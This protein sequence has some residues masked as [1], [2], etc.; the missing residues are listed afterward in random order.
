ML[1][2]G[3]TGKVAI[4]TGGSEGL[5]RAAALRAL[6]PQVVLSMYRNASVPIGLSRT[7]FDDYRLVV[8]EANTLNNIGIVYADTGQLKKALEFYEQALPLLKTV[9]D[10]RGEGASGRRSRAL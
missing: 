8:R 5:G 3:L 4:V 10:K 2:L 7:L 1:D 6:R 9:G